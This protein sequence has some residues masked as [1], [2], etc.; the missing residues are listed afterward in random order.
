MKTVFKVFLHP[1]TQ[2]NLLVVGFLVLIQT[3]HL[4]AHKTMELD[5]DSYVY[6]FCRKNVEKCERFIDND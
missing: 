6:N 4:H 1:V 2:F 5:A 3:V